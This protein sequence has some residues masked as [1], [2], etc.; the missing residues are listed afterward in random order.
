[1]RGRVGLCGVFGWEKFNFDN[2]GTSMKHRDTRRTT[3][4][5]NKPSLGLR[6][7]ETANLLA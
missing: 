6:E 3:S 2:S 5:S 7:P 4:K 1:M